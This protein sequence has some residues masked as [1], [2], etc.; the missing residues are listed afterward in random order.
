MNLSDVI[1]TLAYMDM[2]RKRRVLPEDPAW[3][4]DRCSLTEDVITS[5]ELWTTVVFRI[6]RPSGSIHVEDIRRTFY[7]LVST[8]SHVGKQLEE[9][10]LGAM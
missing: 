6:S 2:A 7:R 9:A 10:G 3:H 1:G 8:T 5:H 4:L